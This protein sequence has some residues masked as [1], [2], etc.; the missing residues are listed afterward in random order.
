[1]EGHE[2]I[3]R[4]GPLS[5]FYASDARFLTAIRA[6]FV[7]LPAHWAY[8]GRGSICSGLES[9]PGKIVYDASAVA[10]EVV[11]RHLMP[12]RAPRAAATAPCWLVKP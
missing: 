10:V 4:Q 2:A 12:N 11:G 8:R 7:M 6:T 5:N 9:A 1:M 3:N